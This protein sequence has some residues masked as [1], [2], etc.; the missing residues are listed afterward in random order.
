MPQA[1]RHLLAMLRWHHLCGNDADTMLVEATPVLV[2][3]KGLRRRRQK[4][5]Q[6]LGPNGLQRR[7]QCWQMMRQCWRGCGSAAR[8]QAVSEDAAV[9]L[10]ALQ[11]CRQ[12]W[13][14]AAAQVVKGRSTSPER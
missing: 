13:W 7:R 1:C 2:G 11:R 9:A 8:L 10:T 4:C 12:S 3:L 5:R 14:G 6:R